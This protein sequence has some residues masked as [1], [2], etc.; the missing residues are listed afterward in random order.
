[1]LDVAVARELALRLLSGGAAAKAGAAAVGVALVAGGV[2]E[3]PHLGR[4]E[5][6][7][8]R[9][10]ATAA[11]K[12][13]AAS[14]PPVAWASPTP[15]PPAPVAVDVAVR[16]SRVVSAAPALPV[17][18]GD[19][20]EHEAEAG[21]RGGD[22]TGSGRDDGGGQAPESAATPVATLGAGHDGGDGSDESDGGSGHWRDGGGDSH[23]EGGS[24]SVLSADES[25][26]L[27]HV[28]E[29]S[30]D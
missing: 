4:P 5:A 22:E 1:V 26:A 7:A 13:P 8:V 9:P 27:L 30:G 6:H 17:H 19:E 2:A 14:H 28:G 10:A 16:A 25:S 21:H 15:L 12:K 29:G 18:H 23:G 20:V 11:A 24:Q 3:R